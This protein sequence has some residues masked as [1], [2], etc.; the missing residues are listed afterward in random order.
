MI[1]S[2]R[3]TILRLTNYYWKFWRL[4]ILV[5][6]LEFQLTAMVYTHRPSKSQIAHPVQNDGIHMY[7]NQLIVQVSDLP[8]RRRLRSSSTLELFVPSYRLITIGRRSLTV[9]LLQ[10]QSSGTPFPVHLQSSPSISTFQPKDIFVSTISRNHHSSSDIPN[11]D[12]RGI[13]NDY[14]YSVSDWLIEITIPACHRFNMNNRESYYVRW[15]CMSPIYL[16]Y[17]CIYLYLI[18]ANKYTI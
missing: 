7:L 17:G 12:S 6:L 18:N 13:Q 14:C 11:Y 8:G 4:V 3:E 1:K 9:I 10:P 5:G 15:V 2:L 16:E